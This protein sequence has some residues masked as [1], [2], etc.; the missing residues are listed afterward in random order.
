VPAGAPPRALPEATSA[1]DI[2]VLPGDG[3]GPEITAAARRVLDAV[4]A[5]GGLGLRF[6]EAAIGLAA[7]E[8]HG[9][10]L[11]DPVLRRIAAVDGIVLVPVSTYY[12]PPPAPAYYAPGYYYGAPY[13]GPRY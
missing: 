7:L 10:T 8:R 9:T 1:M 11:P 6:E 3:I 12:Y 4:N 2:L 5:A 13:Y